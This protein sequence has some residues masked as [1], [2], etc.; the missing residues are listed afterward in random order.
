MLFHYLLHIGSNYLA[1][2]SENFISWMIV[3]NIASYGLYLLCGFIAGV[4]AKSCKF[5]VGCIAGLVAALVAIQVFGVGFGVHTAE[6][7]IMLGWG[8]ILGGIG[9][10]LPQLFGRPVERSIQ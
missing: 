9:G 7:L 5:C 2:H 3:L 6:Y 10:V 4:I 1:S 8:S